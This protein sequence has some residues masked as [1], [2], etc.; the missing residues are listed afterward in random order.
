MILVICC[1]AYPILEILWYVSTVVFPVFNI[2]VVRFCMLNYDSAGKCGAMRQKLMIWRICI[3]WFN[4]DDGVVTGLGTRS[5][6]N[7]VDTL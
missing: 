7:H 2:S 6:F 5:W 1:I 3:F 4:I